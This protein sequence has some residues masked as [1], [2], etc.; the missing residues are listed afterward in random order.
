MNYQLDV[1]DKKIL[2]FLV[3]YIAFVLGVFL[4]IIHGVKIQ[5]MN[6]KD[7]SELQGAL[8]GFMS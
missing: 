6:L 2:D 1:I 3:M 8:K 5:D 7:Y 4:W